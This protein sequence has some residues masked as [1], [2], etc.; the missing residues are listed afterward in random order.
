MTRDEQAGAGK[1]HLSLTSKSL[2]QQ[3]R[4]DFVDVNLR[5][6]ENGPLT[7]QLGEDWGDIPRRVHQDFFSALGA[8]GKYNLPYARMPN[9]SGSDSAT[10]AGNDVHHT[11]RKPAWS[12]SL[13]RK[14]TE[15]SATIDG[16]TTTVFPQASAAAQPRASI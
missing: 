8:A 11:R 1:T 12:T 6:D 13:A 10:R 16:F 15:A 7:A 2:T 4:G 3:P 14:S 5:A 9:Q